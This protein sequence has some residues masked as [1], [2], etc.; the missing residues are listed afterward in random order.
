MEESTKRPPTP[1]K[2]TKKQ[3]GS[4]RI[5]LPAEI[6]Y[7]Y[8]VLRD[9]IYFIIWLLDK[10]TVE[11]WETS[12]PKPATQRIGVVLGGK[13]LTDE[14]IAR[15][16]EI[17]G[18]DQIDKKTVRNWRKVACS[19]DMIRTCRAPRGMK[20]AVVNTMKW[21]STEPQPELPDWAKLK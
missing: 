12:T 13:P 18:D 8:P 2:P 9:A 14:E 11:Y 15:E 20:Y 21:P 6:I 16:F 19:V 10:V 1:T 7:S 3:S 17:A 4:Y 5:N